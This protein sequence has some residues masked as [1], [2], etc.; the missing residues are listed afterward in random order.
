VEHQAG[1]FGSLVDALRS[2]SLGS[3][4]AVP[5]ADQNVLDQEPKGGRLGVG[6]PRKSQIVAGPRARST[7]RPAAD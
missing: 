6:G 3:L 4:N 7:P 2:P 1:D 5:K